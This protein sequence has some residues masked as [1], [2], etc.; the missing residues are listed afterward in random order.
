MRRTRHSGQDDPPPPRARHRSWRR[1]AVLA[2][3]PLLALTA[4]SATAQG[5][6]VTAAPLPA[7]DVAMGGAAANCPE[8]LHGTC[9]Y[10]VGPT[11]LLAYSP[12]TGAWTTLPPVKTPRATPSTATAP[13]PGEVLGDCV[14]AIGGGNTT[15]L[16]TAEAYSTETNTWL[17]LPSMPTAR[18]GSAAAT[19]PCVEGVGL[20]GTC[21]YVFGG[22]LL[23][24]GPNDVVATVEAYS[25]ATNTWA[26]V[27]PMQTPR[28]GHGG[29]AAPCPEGLGLHGTCVYA[30]GGGNSTTSPLASAEV[31]SPALNAWL[32]IPDMPTARSDF[33][34]MV[35]APCPEGLRNGCVYAMGGLGTSTTLATVEAY[36][37]VTNAWATM[38]SMPTP[39][40]EFAGAAAPCP[41]NKDHTCAY[42]FGGFIDNG[43]NPTA[44]NE[45]FTIERGRHETGPKPE[46]ES[47]PE[48]EPK[49]KPEPEHESKPEPTPP[50]APTEG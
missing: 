48:H 50:P 25:P 2:L 18:S 20:R 19:A 4:A 36:S 39:H 6:W 46:H 3:A 45:A 37:P 42:A 8:G 29:T 47:K 5:V 28:V 15:A 16:A 32:S 33:F 23:T 43:S 21:V 26:T 34:A 41:K 40:R 27:T 24:G 13:C 44:A 12:V 31:Y 38:P 49:P 1:L 9:V 7:P 14:Y 10:S 22:N 30:A 35:A 11:N 17:T